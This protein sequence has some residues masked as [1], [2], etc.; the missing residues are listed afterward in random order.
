MGF[1][2][3]EVPHCCLLIVLTGMVYDTWYD[4]PMI[5]FKKNLIEM[6]RQ[7]KKNRKPRSFYKYN[8]I[9]FIFE[10]IF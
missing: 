3:P 10:N 8:K 6:V 1:L 7:F 9:T 4:T 2:K 5:E